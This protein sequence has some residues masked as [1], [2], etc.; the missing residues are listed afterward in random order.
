MRE[1]ENH[2]ELE[3]ILGMLGYVAKFI[4]NLSELN[5]PIR[6]LKTSDKWNWTSEAKQ[7]FNNVKKALSSTKV[8]RYF[9]T[10][11]PV[12]LSV[13]ASMKGLGSAVIQQSGVVAFASRALTSAEQRFAQIEK[14]MIAMMLGCEKFHKLL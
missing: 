7:S 13:D 2:A 5:A 14:E 12:S 8:L 4:P 3:T 9:D 11:Q 10:N 1:L 6:D